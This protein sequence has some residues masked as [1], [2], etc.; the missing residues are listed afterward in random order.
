LLKMARAK[1]KNMF[2]PCKLFRIVD[3]QRLV[4]VEP[5]QDQS[6]RKQAQSP[7]RYEVHLTREQEIVSRNPLGLFF[8]LPSRPIE[9]GER[10]FLPFAGDG[11]DHDGKPERRDAD[12][13]CEAKAEASQDP[14]KD[15]R[16]PK[17]FDAQIRENCGR[18]S[19]KNTMSRM[20]AA[21]CAQVIV[22]S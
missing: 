13:P 17:T 16:V 19:Y 2:L 18:S 21:R 14:C 11:R 22:T 8:D 4:K 3:F 5:R 6:V 1:I 9:P 15:P 7:S 10:C 12:E 20:S